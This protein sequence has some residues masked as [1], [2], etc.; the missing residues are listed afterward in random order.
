MMMDELK[1]TLFERGKKSEVF[2]YM[3]SE[4]GVYMPDESDFPVLE[5]SD[6]VP[7]FDDEAY[8]REKGLI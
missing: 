1:P 2:R 7:E 8:N 3:Q 6:D 4:K 5:E